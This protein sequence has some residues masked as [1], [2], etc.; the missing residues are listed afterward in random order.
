MHKVNQFIAF[1]YVKLTLN[2]PKYKAVSNAA[3]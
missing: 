1:V 3:L 2:K